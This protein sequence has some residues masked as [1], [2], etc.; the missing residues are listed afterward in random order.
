MPG[1]LSVSRT[2]GDI[3]SKEIKFGVKKDVVAALPD[4]V[5]F[6]LNDDYN[7]MVIGC[8]GI[9]DVLSIN[10]MLECIKIVLIINKNKKK[11]MNYVEIL[12][13]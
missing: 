4:V 9:F 7:F 5:E 6:E 2:F 11:L 13:L 8:V 12:L 3:Q 1:G 10:D